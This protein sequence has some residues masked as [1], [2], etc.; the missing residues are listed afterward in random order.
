MY[1]KQRHRLSYDR[2]LSATVALYFLFM[3]ANGIAGL[4]ALFFL[5]LTG[6]WPSVYLFLGFSGLCLS[7]LV[8]ILPLAR[9]IPRRWRYPLRSARLG[10][11]FIT[12]SPAAVGLIIV[13]KLAGTGFIAGRL[14]IL[15]AVFSQDIGFAPCVVFAAGAML[16]RLVSITPGALG[17][18]EAIV[19]G[20]SAALG[21]PFGLAV[22]VTVMDRL[23]GIL[24]AG[25]M[26]AVFLPRRKGK[27][28]NHSVGVK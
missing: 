12:N 11:G 19:G 2:Y 27:V 17:V 6:A 28:E 16:T 14:W 22:I 5:G 4:L 23:V 25:M 7:V 15:F 24:G 20:L 8:F 9:L 13:L 18:R 10:W 3:A 21:F 26:A 1:L